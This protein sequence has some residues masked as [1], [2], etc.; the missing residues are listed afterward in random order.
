MEALGARGLRKEM[1]IWIK[2]AAG[3]CSCCALD[4]PLGMENLRG[5]ASQ[6]YRLTSYQIPVSVSGLTYGL[7]MF[8]RD[9]LN[10]IQE[11]EE[12]EKI[13]FSNTSS[14]KH[15]KLC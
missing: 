6:F 2:L 8:L 9:S 14:L 3:L 12:P 1:L 10:Y 15:G 13:C 4:L 11:T 5:T 7:T